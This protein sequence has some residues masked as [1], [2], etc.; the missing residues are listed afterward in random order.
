MTRIV[1]QPHLYNT[2]PILYHTYP[3]NQIVSPSYNSFPSWPYRFTSV[4]TLSPVSKKQTLFMRCSW[5][6]KFRNILTTNKIF[7]QFNFFARTDCPAIVG[8]TQIAHQGGWNHFTKWKHDNGS[9]VIFVTESVPERALS[10]YFGTPFVVQ[11]KVFGPRSPDYD[12][13]E[14]LLV[15]ISSRLW[16][17]VVSLGHVFLR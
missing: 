1:A 2:T 12:W 11:N 13:A 15:Q 5:Q 8:I 3:C 4:N 9:I 16:S 10:P 6:C 17:P 7:L 14:P